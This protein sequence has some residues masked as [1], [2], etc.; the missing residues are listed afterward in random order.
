M[1]SFKGLGLGFRVS[2]MVYSRVQEL[3]S[4]THLAEHGLHTMASVIICINTCM[5]ILIIN[6][7]HDLGLPLWLS[8]L[9]FATARITYLSII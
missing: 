9:C 5:F 6:R 3:I 2:V 1:G 4:T 8:L 7:V